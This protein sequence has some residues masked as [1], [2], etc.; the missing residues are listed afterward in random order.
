MLETLEP[1]AAE[2]ILQI[3]ADFAADPRAEK[4]DLGV[5]VYRDEAGNTPVLKVVKKAEQYL[6]DEQRSKTYMGLLG[7]VDFN[8]AV[9]ELILGRNT[10]QNRSCMLQ[11]PGG[12]GALRLLFELVK[13]ASPGTTIWLPDPSWANH[14]H[15]IQSLGFPVKLYPYY[16]RQS[17]DI[18]FDAMQA[19]LTELSGNDVVLLHGCCH[20]PTGASLTPA[21]WD[22]LAA[23]A[24]ERGFIPLIDFAYQGF[25]ADLDADAYGVRAL[26]SKV[27]E[28]LLAYSCS[29]NFAIYRERTG[30]ALVLSKD[31]E[32]SV[33]TLGQMKRLVRANYSMPPDH[34]AAI[35]R[36]ILQSPTLKP[37][38]ENELTAM[39]KRIN[40]LRSQI[41]DAFRQQSDS[42]KYDFLACQQGMFSQL[43]LTRDQVK[44]L[45][46]EHA[47]YMVGDSRINLAGLREKQIGHLVKAVLSVSH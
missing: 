12:S 28:L 38:W 5:G 16:R 32:N 37:N 3:S 15:I 9:S 21:Q 36:T 23:L 47:I 34:G 18:D 4:I 24:S 43:G 14:Q 30:L 45:R 35:V 6:L 13:L 11:T 10:Q 25:G 1:S 46:N 22:I 33:R 8:N 17:C 2:P 19:S 7:D 29:K 44:T 26:Y 31:S 27:D 20:N 39:R 40:S 41:A 42:V